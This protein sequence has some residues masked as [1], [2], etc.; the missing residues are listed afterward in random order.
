MLPQQTRHA[1]TGKSGIS[2]VPKFRLLQISPREIPAAQA[3]DVLKPLYTKGGWP[4]DRAAGSQRPQV[5]QPVLSVL[6]RVTRKTEISTQ[7]QGQP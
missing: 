4:C 2:S 5:K 7:S 1:E 3:T 6:D